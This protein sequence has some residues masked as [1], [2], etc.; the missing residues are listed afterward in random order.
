MSLRTV[1]AVDMAPEA[2]RVEVVSPRFY[3]L[4]CSPEPDLE[5]T[6]VN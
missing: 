1:V 5:L 3:I 2:V 6:L 4:I